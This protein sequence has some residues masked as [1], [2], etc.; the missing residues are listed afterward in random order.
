MI[1]LRRVGRLKW[2]MDYRY[3]NFYTLFLLTKKSVSTLRHPFQSEL[4][5]YKGCLSSYNLLF[6]FVPVH[7]SSFKVGSCSHMGG[8]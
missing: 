3:L 1:N 6:V 4:M 8:Y 5:N 7:G 2:N